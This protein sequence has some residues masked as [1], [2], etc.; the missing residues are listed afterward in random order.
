[1][2]G[3]DILAK[4][5]SLLSDITGIDPRTITRDTHLRNDL[6]ITSL[7]LIELAVRSEQMSGVRMEDSIFS[8]FTTI[9]DVV[10]YMERESESSPTMKASN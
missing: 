5:A 10:D 1:M 9:G 8:G 6:P 7:D 4:L 3:D 2:T